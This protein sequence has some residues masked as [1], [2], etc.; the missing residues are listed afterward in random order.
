MDKQRSRAAPWSEVTAGGGGGGT[1]PS[2]S[3]KVHHPAAVAA[4]PTAT[5][6]YEDVEHEEGVASSER[7]AHL[8]HLGPIGP[9]SK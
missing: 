1:V 8:P 3:D 6:V 4:A 7:G 2:G 9:P 5:G